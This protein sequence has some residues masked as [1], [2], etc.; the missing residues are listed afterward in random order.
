MMLYKYVLI[1]L[2]SRCIL[3]K[4]PENVTYISWEIIFVLLT[5]LVKMPVSLEELMEEVYEQYY[6][7]RFS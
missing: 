6:Q 5:G 7:K 2:G 3:K 1:L 4:A